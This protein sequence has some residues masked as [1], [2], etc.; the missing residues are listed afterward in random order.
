VRIDEAQD[1]LELEQL[2]EDEAIEGGV[3]KFKR[4]R[5]TK[6]KDEQARFK[7]KKTNK[8][9]ERNRGE[10]IKEERIKERAKEQAK[11]D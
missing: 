9:R 4:I 7:N 1:E 10:R 3:E 5:R 11:E 6:M 8:G 2:L